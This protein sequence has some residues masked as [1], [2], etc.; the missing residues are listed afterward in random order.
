MP[1][2]D[3]DWHDSPNEL[4]C[5]SAWVLLLGVVLLGWL[6]MHTLNGWLGRLRG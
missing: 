4:A 3:S 5:W 2:R 6:L 1:C